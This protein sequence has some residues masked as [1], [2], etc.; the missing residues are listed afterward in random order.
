MVAV[1]ELVFV[2]VCEMLGLGGLASFE[3]GLPKKP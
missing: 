1:L 3:P 2:I